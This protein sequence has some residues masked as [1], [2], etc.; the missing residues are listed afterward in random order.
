MSKC[1][2]NPDENMSI[3]RL[4]RAICIPFLLA[5]LMLIGCGGFNQAM[6]PAVQTVTDNFDGAK[7]VHQEPVSSSSKLSEDWHVLGFE[8]TDKS[9]NLV[10]LIAGA[11]GIDNIEGLSFNVDGKIIEAG[12]PTSAVTD[13]GQGPLPWSTRRFSISLSDFENISNAKS[14]KMKVSKTNTYTVSSFG[15]ANPGAIV[16]GKIAPFLLAVSRRQGQ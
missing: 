13:Y 1:E 10:T 9:P 7:I 6:T 8:W 5:P 16:D 2:R 12:N 14:V 15:P 11:R 4:L 3:K